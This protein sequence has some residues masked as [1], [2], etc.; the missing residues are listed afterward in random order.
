MTARTRNEV[1]ATAVKVPCVACGAKVGEPCDP[2]NR[3]RLAAASR[4]RNANFETL[5]KS[6]GPRESQLLGGPFPCSIRAAQGFLLEN[7]PYVLKT[8][9]PSCGAA[10]D[11]FCVQVKNPGTFVPSP[12]GPRVKLAKQAVASFVGGPSKECAIPGCTGEPLPTTDNEG[13]LCRG[14]P[15]FVL[16]GEGIFLCRA[17]HYPQWEKSPFKIMAWLQ[18]KPGRCNYPAC[19][20]AGSPVVYGDDNTKLCHAHR[21]EW[22]IARNATMPAAWVAGKEGG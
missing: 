1:Y 13:R 16:V 11:A 20:E 3:R 21:K 14:E 17:W 4:P 8:P 22:V 2:E 18:S 15:E 9:C 6:I 7:R 5:L 19:N 10:I 12:H